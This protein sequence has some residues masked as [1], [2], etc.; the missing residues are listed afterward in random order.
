MIYI[1]EFFVS[2]IHSARPQYTAQTF[3]LLTT[4]PSKELADADQTI[5]SA[6]LLNAA[7]MQRLKWTHKWI[8]KTLKTYSTVVNLIQ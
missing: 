6:G 2:I 7:I 8:K 3:S 4:F 5:E 1:Y